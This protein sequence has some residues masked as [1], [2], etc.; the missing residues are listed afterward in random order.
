MTKTASMAIR[1]QLMAAL[2]RLNEGDQRGAAMSLESLITLNAL[3]DY[4]VS[5]GF[6]L[7]DVENLRE[8]IQGA[9]TLLARGEVELVKVLLASLASTLA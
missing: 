7:D 5:E 1:G 4:I 3:I 2:D 6:D 8:G 9:L